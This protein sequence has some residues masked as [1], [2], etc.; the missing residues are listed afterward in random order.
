MGF[1]KNSL[2]KYLDMF[3]NLGIVV[4]VIDK[5]EK[6]IDE[7]VIRKLRSID[8]DSISNEESFLILKE[9]KGYYE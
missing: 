4:E 9:L 3:K 6:F 8:L 2:D 1:P 5:E 7:K